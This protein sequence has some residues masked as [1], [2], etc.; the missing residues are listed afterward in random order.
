MTVTKAKQ[1]A[2]D[3]KTLTAI[4]ALL[5][6]T[7]GVENSDTIR[8]GIGLPSKQE[9]EAK[10]VAAFNADK[11]Y[12]VGDLIILDAQ[13]SIG[14]HFGWSVAPGNDV[15][16]NFWFDDESPL[17][18]HLASR[19]GTYHVSLV[20]SNCNGNNSLTQK[21]TVKGD[22]TK[23]K[24][25]PDQPTPPKPTPVWKSELESYSF[26]L[27]QSVPV[28]CRKKSSDIAKMIDSISSNS[29]LTNSNQFASAFVTGLKTILSTESS[30]DAW[31]PWYNAIKDQLIKLETE[32]TFKNYD[33]YKAA[34]D[35]I[36]KG[37]K[38]I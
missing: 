5:L 33:D 1:I 21:I 8:A 35:N 6:G 27:A 28:E 20:A 15:D 7:M 36:S 3:P 30:L 10:P 22:T 17:I 11:I 31:R 9:T 14:T 32:N 2:L 12:N 23:P 37:L 19:A 25:D 4:I 34:W 38:R 26:D 13:E 24:P 16:Q 18:L 29:K